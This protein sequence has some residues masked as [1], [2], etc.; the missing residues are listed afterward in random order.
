M[1]YMAKQV[2]KQ[3]PA[4]QKREE[5]KAKTIHIARNGRRTGYLQLTVGWWTAAEAG[6]IIEGYNTVAVD[7]TRFLIWWSRVLVRER[8]RERE[9]R[10]S[11]WL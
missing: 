6:D 3:Q 2:Q 10:K 7:D 8:E 4:K 1:Q 9:K 11:G 5:K